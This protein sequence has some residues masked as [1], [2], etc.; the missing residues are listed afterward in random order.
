MNKGVL[1]LSFFA[2]IIPTISL[3]DEK[4]VYKGKCIGVHDGDTITVL[5]G[6]RQI[7]VRIEGIDA[8]ELGQDFSQRSKQFLSGLVFGQEVTVKEQSIDRH[9][10]VVGRVFIGDHDISPDMISAG[11]AWHFKKYSS[12]IN[13]SR[14]EK[15]AQFKKIGIWSI[16]N[17]LAPWNY[18]TKFQKIQPLVSPRPM[19]SSPPDKI[20]YTGPRGGKYHINNKGKKVYIREKEKFSGL[21]KEK[22]END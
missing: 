14:L 1:T 4:P 11:L 6:N 5:V 21:K 18:R 13:F 19:K 12:D 20:I 10:R 17:P 15:S 9:G 3:Q 22:M 8:P 16:A 7:K 2:L